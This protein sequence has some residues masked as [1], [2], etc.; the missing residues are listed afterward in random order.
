MASWIVVSLRSG[1]ILSYKFFNLDSFTELLLPPL[2]SSLTDTKQLVKVMQP[3]QMCD[4]IKYDVC[5]CYQETDGH[6]VN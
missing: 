2:E 6:H 1:W 5:L 4:Y 3:S